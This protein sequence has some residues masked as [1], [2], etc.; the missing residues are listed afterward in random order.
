[1]AVTQYAS[2][3][4]TATISTEHVVTA[5]PE[6]TA[7]VYQFYVDINALADASEIVEIRVREKARSGDTQRT[8]WTATFRG[9]SGRTL[10]VTPALMLMHGWDLTIRQTTGTGR[11]FLWSVRKG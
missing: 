2:G 5:N 11:A 4:Q 10:V 7:G 1:V 3:S 9:G 8:V 6:T